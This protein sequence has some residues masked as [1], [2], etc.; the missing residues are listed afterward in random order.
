MGLLQLLAA[1]KATWYPILFDS[2]FNAV[3]SVLTWLTVALAIAYVVTFIALN[4][5]PIWEKI[6]KP[7][8]FAAILYAAAVAITLLTMTFVEDGIVAILFYPLLALILAIALGAILL[9]FKRSTPIYIAVASIVAAG[10]IAV[11]VCMGV[12]FSGGKAAEMN[13][14]SND[15]VNPLALYIFAAVALAV[16]VFVALFI[17]RKDKTGFTTKSITYGAISVAMSFALSY[18]RIVKMPQGGSITVASLLPLMIYAFMFGVKKGV[19]VGMVYGLLQA[20]QDTYILHPAQ[21]VL[22]YPA[23]FACIG[24]AGLFVSLGVLNKIPQLQFALGAIVAGVGRF[25]M[26]FIS[27]I[28]AFGAFAP[29]GTP[30][31]LYSLTYQCFYVFPDLAICIVVGVIL[32][33]SKAFVRTLRR[34]AA[35]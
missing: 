4:D 19:F 11:L 15:D 29:E 26:H 9:V 17:G 16:L 6:R 21:F 27:G 3:R 25:L 5:K 33:S 23:A 35:Q 34:S 13:W 30:V 24:L 31:P 1:D 28:F 22:D 32:F 18:L 12:H 20:I 8:F 7:L 10:V 14:I 2:T